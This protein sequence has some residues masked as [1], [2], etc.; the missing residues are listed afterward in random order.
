MQA[1]RASMLRHELD[2]GAAQFKLNF[3]ANKFGILSD[4]RMCMGTDRC[5]LSLAFRPAVRT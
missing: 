4:I 3:F 1:K 2:R 5:R